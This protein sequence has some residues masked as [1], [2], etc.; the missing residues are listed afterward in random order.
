MQHGYNINGVADSRRNRF[1]TELSAEMKMRKLFVVGLDFQIWTGS[2]VLRREDFRLGENGQL[3]PDDL[4]ENLGCKKLI[5]TKT[6]NVFRAI[7]TRARRLLDENGVRFMGGY[8]VPVDRQQTVIA[9]LDKCVD[10]FNREKEKF[11]A[12]YQNLVDKWIEEHP[13]LSAQLRADGK[14]VNIVEERLYADYG[15]MRLQP[16]AGDEARFNKKVDS[17]SDALFRDVAQMAAEYNRK[18]VLGKEKCRSWA[19]LLAIRNKL[20]GLAFLDGGIRPI[21]EMI[22][23]VRRHLP[24]EGLQIVGPAFVELAACIS[25][26]S[27]ESAMRGVADGTVTLEKMTRQIA[28]SQPQQSLMSI[29]APVH[30]TAPVESVRAV[31]PE[32]SVSDDDDDTGSLFE[33]LPADQANATSGTLSEDAELEDLRRFFAEEDSSA[34]SESDVE[35]SQSRAEDAEENQQDVEPDDE[36]ADF[37]A[38]PAHQQVNRIELPDLGDNLYL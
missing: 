38:I 19:P 13:E 12:N 26:L 2:T 16:V 22:D 15:T 20:E 3:P 33:D 18:A 11:L 4:V 29:P 30:P 7:K 6:L 28:A 5:D 25:V 8:A 9:G 27:Q 1:S 36:S 14:S 24:K 37:S 32:Q 35:N 31:K 23:A 34:E 17:L 10:D 21:I